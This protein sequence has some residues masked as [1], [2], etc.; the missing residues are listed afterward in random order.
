MN[1]VVWGLGQIAIDYSI[2]VLLGSQ[3]GR[4]VDERVPPVPTLADMKETGN[5]EEDAH[6]VLSVTN[7][8]AYY[9]VGSVIPGSNPQ[10]TVS[11]RELLVGVL[12]QRMGLVNK[13]EWVRF[14]ARYS[15]LADMETRYGDTEMD[16]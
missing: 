12:K 5:I 6:I 9:P 10:R 11:E 2:P 15:L 4:R 14:D 8:A 16:F 1:D 7:F 3:V 13:W